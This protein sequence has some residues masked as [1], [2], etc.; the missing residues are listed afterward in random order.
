MLPTTSTS[1]ES[2]NITENTSDTYA[3]KINKNLIKGNIE[4]VESMKQAVYKI[5]NT[6]RYQ[7]VIYSWNYGIELKRLIGKPINYVK[8]ELERLITEALTQDSRIS[9]VDDF[10]IE[11]IDKGTL[12]AS[13][14]V[15]TE[16][17][18]FESSKVVVI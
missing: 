13:F 8:A 18:T 7:H 1:L 2:F 5:L 15:N 16:F 12:L 17:G 9:S 10:K 4:K 6:E 14:T 11:T 3:M